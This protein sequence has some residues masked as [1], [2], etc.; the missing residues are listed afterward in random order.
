[1]VHFEC[2]CLP[3]K[4]IFGMGIADLIFFAWY[5]TAVVKKVIPQFE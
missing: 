1:M 2:S 5:L 3:K 4:P